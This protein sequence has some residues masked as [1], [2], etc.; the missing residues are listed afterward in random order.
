MDK[1]RNLVDN[2]QKQII[3]TIPKSNPFFPLLTH[4]ISQIHDILEIIEPMEPSRK[5]RA[6]NIIGTAWKYIAGSPDHDDFETVKNALDQTI[7]N[8]NQQVVINDIFTERLQN[9]TRITNHITNAIKKDNDFVNEAALSMQ[10]KLRFTKEELTNIKYAIQWAKQNII[11]SFLLNKKEIKIALEKMTDDNILFTSIEEA[12]E[13][14]NIKILYNQKKLL[15]IIVIPLTSRE[16]FDNVIIKPIKKNNRIISTK[17][18]EIIRNNHKIFGI[19]SKCAI[20]KNV[21]IC[22]SDQLVNISNDTCIPPLL[23]GM[24]SSCPISHSYHV[25]QIENISPGVILLNDFIGTINNE[26]VN[27]TFLI[28]FHN[29]TLQINDKVYRNLEAPLLE[30]SPPTIQQTPVEDEFISLLSLEML[31][32]LHINNTKSIHELKS[33][34]V[35]T[36][37]TTFSLFT[38]FAICLVFI[39]L[40]TKKREKVIIHTIAPTHELIQPSVSR[41]KLHEPKPQRID[42]LPYF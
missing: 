37:Y 32:H 41:M 36:K 35:V 4:E 5:K 21:K 15:Y 12:L 8:N 14:A 19:K 31:N 6:I 30:V 28:K 20:I 10:I 9:L 16:E 1:Y 38:L 25:P 34:S 11:N 26:T 33:D 24:N 22:K 7:Q 17:F 23:N 13:F 29:V 27:G 40:F 39:R 3:Q 2:V 18:N 42:D